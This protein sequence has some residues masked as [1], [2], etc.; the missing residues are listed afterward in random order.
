MV[1]VLFPPKG[2]SSIGARQTA[3][4]DIGLTTPFGNSLA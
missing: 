2:V 4:K 1:L 3:D